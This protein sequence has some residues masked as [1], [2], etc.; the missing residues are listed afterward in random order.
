[1]NNPHTDELQRFVAQALQ[2]DV[3]EGDHT[4]LSTIDADAVGTARLLIK[5]EG[6]LAG[7]EEAIEIFHQVN[8]DLKMEVMF[9]LGSWF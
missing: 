5:E 7:V 2:E 1:M 9:S 6:I 3:G 4:S 8:P